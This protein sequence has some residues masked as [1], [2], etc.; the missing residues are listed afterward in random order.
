MV[1][2]FLPLSQLFIGL[3]LQSSEPQTK[4]QAQIEDVNLVGNFSE[5]GN[6][7]MEVTVSIPSDCYDIKKIDLRFDSERD[8]LLFFPELS[9]KKAVCSGKAITT[10]QWVDL[11]ELNEGFYQVRELMSLKPWAKFKIAKASPV[12]SETIGFYKH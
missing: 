3:L 12:E 5:D 2:A 4:P 8:T 6:T 10:A 1:L 7:R 11:G 9:K